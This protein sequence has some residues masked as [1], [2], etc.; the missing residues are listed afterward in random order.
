MMNW[1]MKK[2]M[3]V[4]EEIITLSLKNAHFLIPKGWNRNHNLKVH[5]W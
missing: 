4:A 2:Q 3:V 1:L 5:Q